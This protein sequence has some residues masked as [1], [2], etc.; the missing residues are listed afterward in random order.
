MTNDQVLQ[1]ATDCGGSVGEV[2]NGIGESVHIL[3]FR[4]EE[5][6]E[7]VQ[8][9]QAEALEKAAKVCDESYADPG[10]NSFLR[11][12]AGSCARTI[13]SLIPSPP[14]GRQDDIDEYCGDDRNGKGEIW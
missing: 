6:Q 1:L 4:D 8:G 11:M 2:K 5:L 12:A 14:A 13:R 10:Y 3:K 9:I 7:F